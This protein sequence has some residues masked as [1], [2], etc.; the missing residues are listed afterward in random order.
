MQI[1]GLLGIVGGDDVGVVQPGRRLDLPTEALH[2]VRVAYQVR[3]DDLESYQ[4]LHEL[5]FSLV[6]FAHAAPPQQRQHAVTRMVG[7]LRR[8]GERGR[9]GSRATG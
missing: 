4:S 9:G 8:E 3:I 5:V 1:A 2:G 6:D 7:Q